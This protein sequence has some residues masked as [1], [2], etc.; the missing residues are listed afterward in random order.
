MCY[1]ERSCRS[2]LLGERQEL[3]RKLAH[4]VAIERH[5]VHDQ[6]P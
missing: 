3:C 6:K 1:Q 4:H 5:N 2:L